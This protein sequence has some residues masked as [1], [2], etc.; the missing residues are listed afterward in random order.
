MSSVEQI[1]ST[2]YCIDCHDLQREKRT[3][4]YVI[5]GKKVTI[6]ETSA[7][8]SI[9]YI[10]K[11]LEELNIHL[12]DIEHIIV[13]HIHLDHAGGAGLLL[14]K[15]PNANVI[16]HT[17]GARHLEDPS[18]LIAGARAVYG[19]D[20][21]NLFNPIVPIPKDRLTVVQHGEQ[22]VIENRTLTFYDSP[23]HANHH[24]A[25]HDSLSNGI[26]TGDTAGIYYRE[27]D[28]SPALLFLP[29]TSP[30]QFNPKAME[31]SIALFESLNPDCIYF[32][33]YGHSN[34][35][36]ELFKQ[37]RHWLPIFIECGRLAMKES[38]DTDDRMKIASDLLMKRFTEYLGAYHIHREHPVYEILELD[39]KVSAM[40]IIDALLKGVITE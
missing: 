4:C 33:H 9:P 30:S 1:N 21:D 38:T 12:H 7:S 29:S 14:E 11:G 13:T 20:F 17:K 34:N 39:A 36:T 35:P 40:G 22:L 19:E 6:I 16:V 26:F 2:I 25:I 24:I 8:P 18:R 15:C 37:L 28:D 3:G 31:K 5:K 10:L 32:G 23:G 27:L